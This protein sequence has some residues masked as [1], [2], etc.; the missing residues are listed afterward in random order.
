[1]ITYLIYFSLTWFLKSLRTQ[2]TNYINEIFPGVKIHFVSTFDASDENG[3]KNQKRYINATGVVELFED[4][5][6][7]S[8]ESSLS[9][10]WD[11]AI[12]SI[13]SRIQGEQKTNLISTE[14]PRMIICFTIGFIG[15]PNVGKSSLI[16]SIFGK[17]VV[18]ASRTPGHTKHF[19]TLHLTTG[20]PRMVRFS[21]PFNY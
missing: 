17:K 1:M 9:L 7:Y 2:W 3:T 5:R 8:N 21:F 14:G 4:V 12:S 10:Q 19:Q 13:K 20:I 15:Q 16:N 18:S 6:S 11:K